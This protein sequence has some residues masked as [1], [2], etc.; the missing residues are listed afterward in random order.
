MSFPSC[1]RLRDHV[2][3]DI[4]G[5]PGS[6]PRFCTAH[7]TGRPPWFTTTLLSMYYVQAL[8]WVSPRDKG[9]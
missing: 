1:S 5:L 2:C 9:E 7:R 8:C 4:R 6:G 3:R